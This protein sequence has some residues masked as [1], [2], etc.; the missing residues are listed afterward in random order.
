M[1]ARESEIRDYMRM[2]LDAKK[3]KFVLFMVTDILKEG[4]QFL[5][6]GDRKAMNRVFDIECKGQGGTWMPGIVSRKKQVAPLLL[7]YI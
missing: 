4:S 2:L 1:L 6:E 5:C 7:S 3:Y